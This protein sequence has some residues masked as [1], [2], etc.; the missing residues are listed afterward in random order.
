MPLIAATSSGRVSCSESG[1]C[2]ATARR[3]GRPPGERHRQATERRSERD[4]RAE[5]LQLARVDDRDVHGVSHELAVERGRDLLGDDDAGPILR[6]GRRA[7]E[8]RRDDD[9]RKLEQRS[10]VRLRREHVQRRAGHLA[11]ADGGLE[12]LLVDELAAGRVD[13][14]H[15]VSHP[16]EGVGVEHAARLRV[17]RKMQRHDVGLRED[18][19]ERACR[20]DAEL[21]EALGRDEGVEGDDAH[22][23]A[24]RPARDLAPDPPETEHAE[25]L[26]GEL[27]PGEA[28]PIPGSRGQ[29]GVCLRHVP[30]EREQERDGM[31]GRGVD[32]RLRSVRDED[33]APCRRVDVDVVD[34]HAGTA[35]HLEPTGS[36]DERRVD[37]GLRADDDRLEVSDDLGEVGVGVLDDVEAAS[38]K[39]ETGLC[40]RLADEDAR[41]SCSD[42]RGVVVRLERPDGG[43]A[44]LD[45]RA[46]LEEQRLDGRERRR[47]VEDVVVADVPDP[48]HARAELAVR[49]RDRDP[50][51]V[52]ELE[53]E[54]PRVHAVGGEDRRHD[55][56]ALLVRREELEAHRLGALAAG[57]A[58]RG[59]TGE[60]A[61]ETLLEEQP[62]A[63]SSAA[64]SVT[65]GV[66]GVDR[67]SSAARMRSQSK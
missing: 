56:R 21:P 8:M 30:R 38:Q 43:L 16:R 49:A 42:T 53:H 67:V 41:P 32:R 61:L 9:L 7:G 60:R 18:V 22:P 66:N 4:E 64:T 40:D 14:P 28:L 20:L 31:L 19:V 5:Q 25:R 6:L 50:E 57:A 47:D 13:D 63:T 52:A 24:E 1:P 15:A 10:R 55:G 45:V 2:T 12:R 23:E 65:A 51:A 3:A 59:V 39:L 35:D 29:R 46:A 48:E 34:P 37:R 27:D 33:S 36:L 11:R 58:E 44:A 62:S 54:L 26:A 17:E